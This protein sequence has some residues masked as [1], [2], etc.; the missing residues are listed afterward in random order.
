VK[1]KVRYTDFTTLTRP[2]SVKEPLPGVMRNLGLL[3][4]EIQRMPKNPGQ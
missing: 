4:L 1:V 3:S 2:I